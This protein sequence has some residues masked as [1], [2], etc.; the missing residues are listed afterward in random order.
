MIDYEWWTCQVCGLTKK[1][2]SHTY[3]YTYIYVACQMER[4]SIKY[5]QISGIQ[6]EIKIKLRWMCVLHSSN[7]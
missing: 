5:K 1:D 3:I 7:K 2:G 4:K 6:N